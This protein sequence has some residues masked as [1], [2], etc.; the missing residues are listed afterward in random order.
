VLLEVLEVVPYPEVLE[1]V[2]LEV[3]LLEVVPYPEVLEVVLR[4]LVVG[5]AQRGY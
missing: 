1:V 3:V 2:L 4:L 5:I